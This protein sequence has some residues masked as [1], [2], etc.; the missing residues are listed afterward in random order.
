MRVRSLDDFVFRV[1]PPNRAEERSLSLVQGPKPRPPGVHGRTV[2]GRKNRRDS[3]F[4]SSCV[5]YHQACLDL[6]G[7]M[8]PRSLEVPDSAAPMP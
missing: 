3:V 7:R 5:G 6:G 2:D 1:V 4:R 8:V